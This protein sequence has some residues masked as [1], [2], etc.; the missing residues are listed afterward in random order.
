MPI[1]TFGFPYGH[2][3]LEPFEQL[4]QLGK[5]FS[6]LFTS[7]FEKTE[8]AFERVVVSKKDEQGRLIVYKDAKTKKEFT[9]LSY[10]V[11]KKTGDLYKDEEPLVVRGKCFALSLVNPI[12]T[13]GAMAWHIG[14][15]PFVIASLAQRTFQNKTA[16]EMAAPNMPGR[17]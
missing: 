6:L 7:A 9:R 4:A 5:A 10:I 13:L 11:E 15:I 17:T 8:E 14:K 3:E 12:Y 2:F 1:Q 16:K